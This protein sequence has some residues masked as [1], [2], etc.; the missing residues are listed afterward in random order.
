MMDRNISVAGVL[1]QLYITRKNHREAKTAFREKIT[2]IGICEYTYENGGKHCYYDGGYRGALDV[3]P[4]EDWCESCKILKPLHDEWIK[5]A[6]QA[7]IALRRAVR[8]GM[9]INKANTRG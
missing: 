1:E 8:F 6:R 5:K 2:E 3:P 9:D 7:G 4:I